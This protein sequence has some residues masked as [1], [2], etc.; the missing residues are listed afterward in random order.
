MARSLSL[1]F[2]NHDITNI[3]SIAELRGKEGSFD[4]ITC[5]S[6]FV[7]LQDPLA[8]IRQWLHY[9]KPSTG[10]IILDVPDPHNSRGGIIL[11]TAQR[12]LGMEFS[13]YNRS[14]VRGLHSLTQLLE[15]AGC[16]IENVEFVEQTGEGNRMLPG[17]IKYA[18]DE[19]ARLEGIVLQD[20]GVDD[21]I[22]L[23]HGELA[24]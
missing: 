6:A 24:P 5:V 18:E 15:N 3:A 20:M 22:R 13:G 4:F 2:V 8:A 1:A 9:L 14:W 7:L 17:T 21:K 19:F 11:E 10:R 12:S 23:R 16:T